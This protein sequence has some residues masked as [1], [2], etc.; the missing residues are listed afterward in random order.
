MDSRI[1]VTVFDWKGELYVGVDRI[2]RASDRRHAPR[3]RL[4]TWHA[5]LPESDVSEEVALLYMWMR[6]NEWIT[7]GAPLMSEAITASP[8]G[9][10]RGEALDGVS[11]SALAATA[12][13]SQTEPPPVERRQPVGLSDG[14]SPEGSQ[15]PLW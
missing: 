4:A 9:D 11:A 14:L 12:L 7:A 6:L 15:P 5:T 10:R 13:P 3:T 8:W 2:G 1:S